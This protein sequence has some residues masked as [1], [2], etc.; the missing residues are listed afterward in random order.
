[1]PREAA[2]AANPSTRTIFLID[3][4]SRLEHRLITEWIGAQ[5][6]EDA[7]VVVIPPSRRPRR[8]RLD[9]RLEAC[10]AADDDP[11]LAP[12]RVAW[13]PGEAPGGRLRGL[14]R[15]LL[16]GDPRDPGRWRQ[17]SIV[18]H[19]P[20]RARVVEAEPA[21]ISELRGRWQEAG[22][23][24][25]ETTGLADFVTRQAYLALERAERRIRGS[26]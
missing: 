10:L 8:R 4:S 25:A 13:L 21:S 11:L 2:R 23:V 18:R 12:L 6:G 24:G 7:E 5:H 20:E 17:R 15:L 3:A 14:L 26:R 22:S 9:P 16:L 1:M 19:H